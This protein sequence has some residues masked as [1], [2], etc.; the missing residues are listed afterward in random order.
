LTIFKPKS[1]KEVFFLSLKLYSR[2]ISREIFWYFK[3]ILQIPKPMNSVYNLY[4]ILHSKSK[5]YTRALIRFLYRNLHDIDTDQTHMPK[6]G[7]GR[8]VDVLSKGSIIEIAPH[9]PVYEIGG[10]TKPGDSYDKLLIIPYQPNHGVFV[11]FWKRG[12]CCSRS[13][14]SFD[15]LSKQIIYAS[16]VEELAS[17]KADFIDKEGDRIEEINDHY[18]HKGDF[19]IPLTEKEEYEMWNF[20]VPKKV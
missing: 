19:N 9:F 2:Y 17:R 4:D 14:L 3:G 16:N 15:Q 1:E 12:V 11:E 5:L 20:E 7:K 18:M 13:I 8:Y 6:T 10:S